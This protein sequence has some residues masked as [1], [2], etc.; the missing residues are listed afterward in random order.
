V[1]LKLKNRTLLKSE[2]GQTAVEYILMTAVVVT[3]IT[4]LMGYVKKRVLGEGEECTPE[5][6]TIVC[7]FENIFAGGNYK[8]FRVLR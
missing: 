6:T 2:S 5:S 8:Y 7:R 3:I 1:A 4:S